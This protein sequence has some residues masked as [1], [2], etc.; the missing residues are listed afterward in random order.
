MRQWYIK[1]QGYA[2]PYSDRLWAWWAGLNSRQWQDTFFYSTTSDWLDTGGQ[3]QDGNWGWPSNAWRLPSYSFTDQVKNSIAV[4]HLLRTPPCCNNQ[5][6]AR[7]LHFVQDLRFSRRRLWRIASPAMLGRV[8]LVGTD[9]SE[10]LSASFIRVLVTLMEEALSS[11]ETS[12]LTRATWL[13]NIKHTNLHVSMCLLSV[14]LCSTDAS[15]RTH[16]DPQNRIMSSSLKH[17]ATVAFNLSADCGLAL[18]GL[19]LMI[20]LILC[21]RA[22][23]CPR[24][25]LLS[26][27]I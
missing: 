17:R 25:T 13:N 27:A 26:E 16:N 21:C 23:D 1:F 5:S 19:W 2:S 10:E 24:F 7:T 8:A 14:L 6:S 20:Y 12:V 15:V 9:V 11:S 3:L 4:S 22:T 18:T